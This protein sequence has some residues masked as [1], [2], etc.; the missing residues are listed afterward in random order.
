MSYAIGINIAHVQPAVIRSGGAAMLIDATVLA[1]VFAAGYGLRAWVSKR[2][3]R[4]VRK[5]R[6]D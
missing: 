5:A 6:G 2:R 3:R 1:G 4:A